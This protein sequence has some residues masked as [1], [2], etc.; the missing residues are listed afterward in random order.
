MLFWQ[1]QTLVI[2]VVWVV[3]LALKCWAF[4]DCVRRPARVFPAVDRQNKGL[5]TALT[6]LAALTGLVFAPLDLLGIAGIIIALVYLFDIRPR[7]GELTYR[8]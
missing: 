3:F 5:W 4:A 7:I 1:T 8:R 2:S 6:G